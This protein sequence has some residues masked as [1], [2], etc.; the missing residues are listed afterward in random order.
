MLEFQSTPVSLGSVATDS[1]GS[2]RT[3]VNI[4][5]DAT[6]G[7]HRLVARGPGATGGIHEAAVTV[8]VVAPPSGRTA[9]E[10]ELPRTG[11]NGENVTMFGA[12]AIIASRFLKWSARPTAEVPGKPPSLQD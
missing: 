9:T 8:S 3:T 12:A 11:I 6:F 1:S 7:Q 5:A 4:P 2:F 10:T